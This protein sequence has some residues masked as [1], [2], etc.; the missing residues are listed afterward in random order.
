MCSFP[1]RIIYIIIVKEIDSKEGKHPV[2]LPLHWWS[3]WT[4]NIPGSLENSK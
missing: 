3:A 2:W 1:I 4:F